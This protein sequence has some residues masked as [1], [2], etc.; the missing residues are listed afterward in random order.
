MNVVTKSGSNEFKGGVNIYW[1][2]DS[3]V[4]SDINVDSEYP[5]YHQMEFTDITATLGGPIVKDRLWFFAAYEYFRDGH[6]FPGSDPD[7]TP[8]WPADR[9]DLK[10]SARINDSNL[11]DGKIYFDEWGYPAAP[12]IYYEQSALAGEVGNNTAWALSYQGIFTDRT[13]MEV[14]YTGW[15]SNDDNLSQTG[16]MEPAYIDYSPPGG[17][18]ATYSGGVYWPFRYDTSVDQVSVTVSHFA[19][20]FVAGDHDFKFGIQ[21]SKGDAVTQSGASET[22]N[23]YYHFTLLRLRLLLQGRRDALL[24]RQRERVGGGVC[25][26]LVDGDRPPDPQPGPALR[27]PQG[28]HSLV[29]AS[30]CR[31]QPDR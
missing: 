1:F 11:I 30:R 5:E 18:P 27:L 15:K 26:R 28:D 8:T 14:R 31:R 23:Y 2:N 7:L 29:P 10:L 4:D 9:Y 19:D 20:D 22:G 3:L 16:S 13:F 6:A 12:S 24:L 21:A 17:G 25:R